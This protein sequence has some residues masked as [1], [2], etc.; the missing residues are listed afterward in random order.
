MNIHKKAYELYKQN[1]PLKEIA[2]ILGVSRQTVSNWKKKEKWDELLLSEQSIDAEAK[3]KEFLLELI[4][5]WDGALIE[6]KE[7]DLA[8]KLTLLEKYTK[9]YYKLKNINKNSPYTQKIQKEKIV[10]STIQKLAEIA[11]KE[12]NEKVAEF[13]K[14]HADKIAEEIDV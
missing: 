7:S 8:N 9:S 4:K 10:F 13:F 12:K 3:E 11:I 14:K 5:E 6:L 2:T 1:I